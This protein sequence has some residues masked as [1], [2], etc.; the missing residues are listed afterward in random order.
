MRLG[1]PNPVPLAFDPKGADENIREVFENDVARTLWLSL[2]S[3]TI[4]RPGFEETCLKIAEYLEENGV[5]N[6][7]NEL[8]DI[9]NG[10][11]NLPRYPGSI[12]Y[13]TEVAGRILPYLTGDETDLTY[14]I[15]LSR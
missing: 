11:F 15:V 2:K 1:I 4:V 10:Y 9:L 8:E 12:H 14:K 13:G 3:L 7:P 5:P 6:S